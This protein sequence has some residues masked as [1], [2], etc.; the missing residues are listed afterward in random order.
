[1]R[2]HQFEKKITSTSE[3]LTALERHLAHYLLLI[4][5]ENSLLPE[6]LHSVPLSTGNISAI[7]P[8][9]CHYYEGSFARTIKMSKKGNILELRKSTQMKSWQP[10]YVFYNTQNA[11]YLKIKKKIN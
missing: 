5:F 7:L 3:L 6:Q 1:L 10:C 2:N 11:I 8:N 4:L 9:V